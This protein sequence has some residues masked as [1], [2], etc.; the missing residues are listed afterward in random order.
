MIT[1]PFMKMPRYCDE[2]PFARLRYSTPLT[3]GRKG[4]NCQV[5]FYEKGKYETVREAP[6][7]E[8]VVPV[9][10]PLIDD[11]ELTSKSCVINDEEEVSELDF[12]QPHKTVEKLISVDVLDK[13]RSE[14]EQMDFD[15]W[16]SYDHTDT[17]RAMVLSIID[18]Y[19]A[20]SEEK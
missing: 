17:I 20:E 10:C 6:Y 2:C 5:E 16:D 12:I 19:K 4:Y 13:I 3:D 9:K 7:D 1:V 15:F 14:I 11:E 18:K 8:Y